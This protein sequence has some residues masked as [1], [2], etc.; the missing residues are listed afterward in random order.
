MLR[1]ITI[2]NKDDG[3][4]T[5]DQILAKLTQEPLNF[6]QKKILFNHKFKNRAYN[7][8]RCAIKNIYKKAINHFQTMITKRT[9]YLVHLKPVIRSC[10]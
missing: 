4:K 5:K 7:K 9:Q 6:T 10:Q 2:A 3:V 8:F 1:N